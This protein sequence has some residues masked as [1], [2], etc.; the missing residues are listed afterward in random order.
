MTK[1][2]SPASNAAHSAV[3]NSHGLTEGLIAVSEDVRL[4]EMFPG[5]F[6]R[7]VTGKR[8]VLSSRGVSRDSLR[9]A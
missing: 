6:Y 8:P 1:P 4:A 7:L 9:D 3:R 2:R 5:R